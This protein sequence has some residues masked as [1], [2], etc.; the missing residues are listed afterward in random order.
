[1]KKRNARGFIVVAIGWLAAS[2]SFAATESAPAGKYDTRPIKE[3][4]TLARGGDVD[5]VH[6]LCYAYSYGEI[7]ATKDEDK[8]FEWCTKSHE[9]GVPSGTTLLAEI[10]SLG[11]TDRR[12]LQRARALYREAA[13]AGHDFAMYALGM[14]L[15][16]DEATFREGLNWLHK[17]SQA[18]IP[19]ATAILEKLVAAAKKQKSRAP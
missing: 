17:A 3:V 19:E 8:A 13:E 1:M 18:G 5:A 15:L 10:H 6:H 2:H 11:S 9:A 7:G 16:D 14:M 12:D 4:I